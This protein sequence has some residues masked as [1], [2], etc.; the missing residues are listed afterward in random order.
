MKKI[1]VIIFML[2]IGTLN[3]YADGIKLD[4]SR[5]TNNS[6]TLKVNSGKATLQ[7]VCYVYR[8]LDNINF[9]KKIIVNCNQSY[10]DRELDS[11]MTYYYRATINGSDIYSDVVTVTTDK[12]EVIGVDKE[13]AYSTMKNGVKIGVFTFLFASFLILVTSMVV[14]KKKLDR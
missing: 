9:D 12:D 8:S 2:L 7:E 1:G 5:V 14:L 3:V 11:D 13:R 10:V 4:I 6:V